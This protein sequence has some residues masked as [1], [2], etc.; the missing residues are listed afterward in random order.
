MNRNTLLLVAGMGFLI[1]IL[2]I[3]SVVILDGVSAKPVIDYAE[4]TVEYG[5]TLWTIAKRIAPNQDP[6]KV[7]WEIQEMNDM[8]KSIIYPGQRIHVPIYYS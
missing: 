4:V 1:A 5:D 6:R 7:V 3:S 2:T 8:N